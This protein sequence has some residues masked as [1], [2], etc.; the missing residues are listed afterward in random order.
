MNKIIALLAVGFLVNVAAALP[1]NADYVQTKVKTHVTSAHNQA[2]TRVTT[3]TTVTQTYV[4]DNT[5]AIDCNPHYTMDD[6]ADSM[7]VL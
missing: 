5:D 6:L 4:A 7:S 1:A 2:Q 3:S